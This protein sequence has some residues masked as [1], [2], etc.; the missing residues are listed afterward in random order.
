MTAQ[1]SCDTDKHW[2]LQLANLMLFA[3]SSKQG[4]YQLIL[5]SAHP[6]LVPTKKIKCTIKCN[7]NNV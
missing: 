1:N 4:E 5:M 7:N 3:D 2:L 6:I